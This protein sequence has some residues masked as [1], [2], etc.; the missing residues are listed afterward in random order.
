MKV[1]VKQWGNSAAIRIPTALLRAA[2]LESGS[3]VDVREE[4]GRIVIR[5]AEGDEVKTRG[6]LLK[7]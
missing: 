2:H 5:P 4:D 3:V 6:K 7:P 1:K